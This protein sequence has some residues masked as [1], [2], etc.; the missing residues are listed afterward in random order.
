MAIE[1]N[2]DRTMNPMVNGGAIAATSM[3]T[4]ATAD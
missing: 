4:D 2:K 1:L 3:A